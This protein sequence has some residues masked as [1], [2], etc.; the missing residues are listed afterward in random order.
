ML[1][2]SRLC[3]PT[4]VGLTERI[5]LPAVSCSVLIG[6]R[7][8]PH[9]FSILCDHTADCWVSNPIHTEEQQQYLPPSRRQRPTD[10][11]TVG[12]PPGA[13]SPIAGSTYW[14]TRGDGAIDVTCSRKALRGTKNTTTLLFSVSNSCDTGCGQEREN[15]YKCYCCSTTWC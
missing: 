4:A 6:R 9:L 5:I 13:H 12:G 8:P 7:F 3:L 14:E 15:I 2:V 10:D 1:L 11:I